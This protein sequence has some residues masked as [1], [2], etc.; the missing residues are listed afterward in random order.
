MPT[1]PQQSI[2]EI[3]LLEIEAQRPKTQVDANL[4]STLVLRAAA[5]RLN[6]SPNA[7]LQQAIL[8]QWSELFRTGL[9]AWGLDLMNPNPPLFHVTDRGS[10]ALANATRDP[11]NPAGYLRHWHPSHHWKDWH[12]PI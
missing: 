5:Q 11:S 12:C 9:L 10:Q 8:T 4:Q 6:A 1:P 2:R 3:L 7:D